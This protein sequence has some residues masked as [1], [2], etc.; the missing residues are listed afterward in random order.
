MRCEDEADGA[1]H[2]VGGHRAKRVRQQ[3][4][5]VAHP[6]VDPKTEPLCRE[7]LFESARLRQRNARERRD[8]PKAFVVMDD[9]LDP[10]GRDAAS[11]SRWRETA[12]S[13][14]IRAPNA[15][16]VQRQGVL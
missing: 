8:T 1:A 3:R 6:N 9:L 16:T 15:T 2:A 4:M 10:L 11:R 13:S 14:G 7:P 12:T 5:P